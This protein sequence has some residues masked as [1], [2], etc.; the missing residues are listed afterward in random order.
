MWTIGDTGM[1]PG[2][3]TRNVGRRGFLCRLC[4]SCAGTPH[5]RRVRVEVPCEVWPFGQPKTARSRSVVHLS[6]A[7]VAALRA[8]E[9]RQ[10]AERL[11]AFNDYAGYGLVFTA[12][13]GTPVQRKVVQ[14]RFKRALKHAGLRKDIRFHD[15]RHAAATLMLANGVDVPTVA[16]VLGHSQN[17]TTLN[18]YAHALPSRLGTAT[19][20]LERAIGTGTTGAS[21]AGDERSTA[22]ADVRQSL[23]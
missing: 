22:Q 16:A 11:A 7:A 4:R 8:H 12:P 3:L 10:R 17:S 23:L 9:A 14:E 13:W 20:A 18:V 2:E 15:L 19:E 5:S 1:R 21:G 6:P